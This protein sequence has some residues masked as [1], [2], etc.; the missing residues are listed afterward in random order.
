MDI[1]FFG[2]TGQ[3]TGLCYLVRVREHRI[4]LECGLIQGRQEDEDRNREPFPFDA[5][6]IDAVVLSHAHIDHSGRLPLLMKQ[7]FTGPIYTHQATRALCA[8]MLRDSGYLHAKDAEWTNRKRRRQ[9]LPLLT[10]LYTLEDGE[11]VL[12]QFRG[13]AYGQRREILPD[14]SIRLR[15]AGHILGAAIVEL[16][17]EEDGRVCKLVFSGDLGFVDAPVMPDPEVVDEADIVLLESTYGDRRH[18]GASRIGILGEE[19]RVNARI[20]TVGGLSAHADQ[21]GLV[22]WYRE[23]AGSPPVYLIHG[24]PEAQTALAE[25]IETETG[26]KPTIPS[27]GDRLDLRRLSG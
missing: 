18:R 5:S 7:G 2:A 25:V 11:A 27:F 6:A 24:E 19:I 17:L 12:G 9:G 22:A 23:F 15:N 8:I 26:R 13:L 14:I 3:V 20:H 1:Q 10:P 4:L 21:P 16:W